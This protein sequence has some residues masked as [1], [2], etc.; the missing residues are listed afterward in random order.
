LYHQ[1]EATRRIKGQ[2]GI[3]KAVERGSEELVA[4][5]ILADDKN[6]DLLSADLRFGGVNQGNV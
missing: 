5:H 2:E 3:H 1:F 6:V 4:L